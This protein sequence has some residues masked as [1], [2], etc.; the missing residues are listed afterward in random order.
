MLRQ[1]NHA[2]AKCW[3]Q[4]LVP[5]IERYWDRDIP[6]SSVA[7]WGK[8]GCLREINPIVAGHRLW[9]PRRTFGAVLDDSEAEEQLRERLRSRPNKATRASEQETSYLAGFHRG[10]IRPRIRFVGTAA[11]I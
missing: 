7:I 5:V 9:L 6:N 8:V 4:V 3:R 11:F 2:S 1:G 10:R